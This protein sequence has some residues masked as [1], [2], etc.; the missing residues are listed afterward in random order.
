LAGGTAMNQIDTLVFPDTA[1]QRAFGREHCA[2]SSVVQNTLDACTPDT[3]SHLQQANM[4]L[5]QHYGQAVA[6]DFSQEYLLL[7]LDL[8]GLLAGPQSEGSTKGYFANHRGASGRQLCR[9]TATAFD[10]ILC[11]RLL[12]GATLS[13][14]TLKPAIQQAAAILQL[15]P[16]QRQD[17]LLRWDAGFG[18]D[19]NINWMLSQG[20]QIIGKMY[21]HKRVRKLARTVTAW[22]PTPSSPGREMGIPP[23]PH[24]YARK[25][26]QLVV[27]T[28]KKHPP[29]TWAYGVLV[30]TLH[31]LTPEAL[32]DLY[33]DRGGGIE[34]EFRAD[35]QGLGLAKRRK[36]RMVAQQML[37]HLAER[38]HNV[39]VWTTHQLDPPLNHYGLLRLVRD[40][41]QITGYVLIR[42][43]TL[44][45]IGLNQRHPL[46]YAVRDGFNRLLT[47]PVQLTLCDPVEHI[48][49]R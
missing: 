38:A 29:N 26:S 36:R 31:H 6:H 41:F 25:T 17:T 37:V 46:V 1:L 14:T 47:S 7:D 19:H 10:E 42:E 39:L 49:E 28:P 13:Q 30:T 4:R 33:D 27:R 3:V 48:K 2:H 22:H 11:Q 24:R 23:L 44:T 45:E 21:A 20:Y 12:S 9:V 18:T 40:A 32:V 8:T 5:Y 43:H 34:T 16:A 15:S 35:R